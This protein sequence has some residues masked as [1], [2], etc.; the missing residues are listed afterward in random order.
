M[1]LL[2]IGTAASH[3]RRA[4]NWSLLF[5]LLGFVIYLNLLN[6]SQ[7]W[8]ASGR[9]GMAPALLGLHGSVFVLAWSLIRWRDQAGGVSGPRE[10]L[11][12]WR[13]AVTTRASA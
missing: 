6:L 11:R 1:V 3:P 5:A 13:A 8:V 7:A 4:S 9:L 2:G 10:W 12:R